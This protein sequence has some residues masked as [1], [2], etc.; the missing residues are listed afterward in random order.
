MSKTDELQMD[1]KVLETHDIEEIISGKKDWMSNYLFEKLAESPLKCI[2]K[3]FPHFMY[4][5]SSLDSIKRPKEQ[6]PIFYG[7]FDWHSAVHSHWSLVRQIRLID[8][9][10]LEN[11]IEEALE[12][13]F[14]EEKGRKELTYFEEN[15]DF[16]KP[17]GWAWFLSLM[18]E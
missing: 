8:D 15:E 16:E 5:L 1:I 6:H 4:S 3:E 10:P 7:C 9:H 14:S 13:S 11:E 12:K 2:E 18:A 17:Y